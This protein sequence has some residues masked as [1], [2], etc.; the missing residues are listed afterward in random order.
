MHDVEHAAIK[1]HQSDQ[2]QI[3]KRDAGESYGEFAA[4]RVIDK[5]RCQQRDHLR[6]E[7]PCDHQQDGLHSEKQRENA[8]GEELGGRRILI[9]EMRISRNESGIE[10]AFRKD[11]SEMIGETK[12][13]EECVSNRARAK[14]C[15]E[16]DVARKSRNAREQRIT[17]DSEDST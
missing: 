6:H 16:H 10:R 4:L 7:Q 8:I 9:I 14:N 15:G 1:R 3:G 17:A 11:R 5:P 13:D 2:Q 12:C